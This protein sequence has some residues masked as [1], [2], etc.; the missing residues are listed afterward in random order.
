MTN[1]PPLFSLRPPVS[2]NPTDLSARDI[3]GSQGPFAARLPGYEPREGQQQVAAAVERLLRRDGVLLCEAGTGIGK[4]FAYL[5]P[6]LLSGRKIVISTAT[7]NLQDQIAERDLPFV[8]K[9]LGKQVEVAVMKGLSN[10]L[11]KRRYKE[12]QLS[13]EA[14]RPGYASALR[15]LRSW[16]KETETGDLAELASIPEESRVRLEI[17]ATSETRLGPRCPEFEECHVTEMRRQAEAAQI[18]IVNHHLFFADLSLRGPHPGRVL[19]DYDAVLFDEAHQIEDIAALFF[20]ERIT[21]AGLER[22]ARDA[23]RIL[24]R[25]TVWGGSLDAQSGLSLVSALVRAA[26]AFFDGMMSFSEVPPGGRGT[27]E[28]ARLPEEARTLTK[29]LETALQDLADSLRG[30][31][32]GLQEEG[33]LGELLEQT[34]RRAEAQQE[35][36]RETMDARPSRVTWVD[37]SQQ[38]FALSST[39]VDMSH[40]LRERL[41]DVVPAVG[42]LSATL[43]TQAQSSTNGFGFVKSRLGLTQVDQVEELTVASPFAYEKQCLLYL[44]RDLPACNEPP[45]IAEST[46]RILQLVRLTRGGAFVLTTS[47]ATM[48]KLAEGLRSALPE[49]PVLLQGE[50]PKEALLSHFR[51]SGSAVLVATASF[52]EGVDVPGP[53]LRLVVLDKLPFAVPTDPVLLAR[54]QALEDRGM[55][56]FAHLALP[57]AA[58]TLKQGFGRLIRHRDDRGIVV[59]LDDRIVTKPYGKRLLQALPPAPRT[60]SWREVREFSERM[61]S[62]SAPVSRKAAPR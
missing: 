46:Q 24:E 47:L 62:A 56:A 11:C 8:Q 31:A 39:P 55:S 9:I 59:I 6:A 19:P 29:A 36:L 16:Q 50:R 35:A 14:L 52:W 45:F 26:R 2:V 41:F 58:I 21:L 20:G 23:S 33:E 15:T 5:I 42:L 7:K 1:L 38:G 49:Y 12:F 30:R 25:A 44:P 57:Q 54:G 28:L 48:R 43:S 18:L 34:A 40:L 37:A 13:E 17:A 3:L 60:S 22:L 53:A 51:A 27:L 4:T 10:Y 61:L 32:V